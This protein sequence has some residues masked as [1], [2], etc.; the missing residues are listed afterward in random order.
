MS[1]P[2]GIMQLAGL[3]SLYGERFKARGWEADPDIAAQIEAGLRLSG[4]D[5]ARALHATQHHH[6]RL[7]RCGGCG[8]CC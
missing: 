7:Q 1:V 8:L 4:V 5:V 3:A 6:R 2:I